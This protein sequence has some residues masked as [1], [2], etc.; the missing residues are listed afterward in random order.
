M[1][2]IAGSCSPSSRSIR[3]RLGADRE[4]PLLARQASLKSPGLRGSCS[5]RFDVANRS[6]QNRADDVHSV[7]L[8]EIRRGCISRNIRKSLRID[9]T[10]RANLALMWLYA[11][12]ILNA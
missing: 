11:W 4:A 2:E 12:G 10:F 7:A 1:G 6:W 8:V 5:K 9:L 3:W